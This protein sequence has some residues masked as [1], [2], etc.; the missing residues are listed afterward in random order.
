MKN[1][2][3]A[4]NASAHVPTDEKDVVAAGS[5]GRTV[6]KLCAQPLNIADFNVLDLGIFAGIQ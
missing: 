5:K 4:N 3:S 6:I 1:Q 2:N